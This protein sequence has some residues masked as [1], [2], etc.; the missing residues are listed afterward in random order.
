MFKKKKIRET[1]SKSSN[2]TVYKK[3]PNGR[4]LINGKYEIRPHYNGVVLVNNHTK[5]RIV[6]ASEQEAKQFVRKER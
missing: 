6:F 2:W 5:Q 1:N 3:S 4:I